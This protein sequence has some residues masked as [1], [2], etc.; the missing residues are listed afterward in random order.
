MNVTQGSMFL[1]GPVDNQLRVVHVWGTAYEMGYAQGLLLRDVLHL[2][3]APPS[4]IQDFR[5]TQ[6]FRDIRAGVRHVFRLRR[7]ACRGR[8]QEHE[9]DSI[10]AFGSA[11]RSR[12]VGAE[13]GSGVDVQGHPQV[14][15][16]GTVASLQ[17]AVMIWPCV[18]TSMSAEFHKIE[19]APPPPAL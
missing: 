7:S 10:S 2:V 18:Y 17:H 16:S 19:L 14:H 3:P 6:D 9:M 12:E 13:R 1:A 15:A 11:R 5:C 4:C 8:H